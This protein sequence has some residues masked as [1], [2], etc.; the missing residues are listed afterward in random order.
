MGAASAGVWQFWSCT[1]GSVVV[2]I[3]GFSLFSGMRSCLVMT[4]KLINDEFCVLG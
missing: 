2:V 1:N 3:L 4:L